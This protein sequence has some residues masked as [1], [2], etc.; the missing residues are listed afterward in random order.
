MAVVVAAAL[1]TEAGYYLIQNKTEAAT[2]QNNKAIEESDAQ[3]AADISNLTGVKSE[4]ILLLK[5]TGLN[6]N[7]VLEHLKKQKTETASA[8]SKESRSS[9][10]ATLDMDE[11]VNKLRADGYQDQLIQNAKM[12]A[13]RIEYQLTEITSADTRNAKPSSAEEE[14]SKSDGE[15]TDQFRKLSERYKATEAVVFMLTLSDDFGGIDAVLDEYLLA[16]QIELDLR[17]YKEDPKAYL[18]SKE[19]K[20]AFLLPNARITAAKIEEAMLTRINRS[21]NAE[22][23]DIS[24]SIPSGKSASIHNEAGREAT[25]PSLPIPEVADVRPVNPSDRLKQEL[26]ALNPNMP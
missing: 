5:R 23:D 26:D 14:K 11:A 8:Q 12:L 24:N 20:T 17:K 1:I 21:M 10:L 2:Q 4:D 16:L 19:E 9:L 3:I 13:E 6:W 25:V 18:K 7:D 22:A 15:D